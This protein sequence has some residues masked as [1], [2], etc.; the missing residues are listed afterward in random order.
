ME[1]YNKYHNLILT[2]ETYN[3]I[4]AMDSIDKYE[5]IVTSRVVY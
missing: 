1:F 5:H 3:M 4:E 2:C